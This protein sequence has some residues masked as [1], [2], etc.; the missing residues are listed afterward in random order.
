MRINK[1]HID[2]RQSQSLFLFSFTSVINPRLME[3]HSLSN[4][5]YI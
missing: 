1:S 3:F 2:F 5:S 4:Y